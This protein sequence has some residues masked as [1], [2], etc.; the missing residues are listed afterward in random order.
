MFIQLDSYIKDTC[1]KIIKMPD[2]SNLNQ[3]SLL[4][5]GKPAEGSFPQI[6]NIRKNLQFSLFKP[7]S[8]ANTK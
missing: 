4:L 7:K 3:G 5:P 8:E 6:S 1:S 2:S